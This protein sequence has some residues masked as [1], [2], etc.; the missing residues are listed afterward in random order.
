MNCEYN[1]MP[2]FRG[3]QNVRVRLLFSVCH[4]KPGESAHDKDALENE[5]PQ[6]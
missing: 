3:G 5:R 4:L 6:I 2:I 1:R